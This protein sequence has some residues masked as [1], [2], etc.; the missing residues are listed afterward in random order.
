[1]LSHEELSDKRCCHQ[2]KTSMLLL[3]GLEIA[4]Q[5]LV[6]SHLLQGISNFP[7]SIQVECLWMIGFAM[8]VRCFG[9]NWGFHLILLTWVS[10]A[11]F[12]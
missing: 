8:G 11:Y 4:S 9:G 6:Y 1:M 12:E 7:F 2:R 5:A 3:E 10:I